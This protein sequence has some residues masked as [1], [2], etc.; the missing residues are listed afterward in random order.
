MVRFLSAR[1]ATLYISA[2]F[3]VER[4][5][6]DGCLSHASIVSKWLNLS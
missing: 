1:V 3:A 5:L 4:C 2:V 6:A